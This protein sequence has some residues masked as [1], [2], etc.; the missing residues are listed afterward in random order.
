MHTSLKK[1]PNIVCLTAAK[2]GSAVITS[3]R[4][5]CAAVSSFRLKP[6]RLGSPESSQVKHRISSS[7]IEK[8]KLCP[9][10]FDRSLKFMTGR[11]CICSVVTLSLGALLAEAA[12]SIPAGVDSTRC[13]EHWTREI[14]A[15]VDTASSLAVDLKLHIHD[16]NLPVKEIKGLFTRIHGSTRT[17]HF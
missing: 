9:R 6:G 14:L 12:A 11:V 10:V 17:T 1:L 2:K 4:N 8:F 5:R 16:A 15:L 3:T 7:R 13:H